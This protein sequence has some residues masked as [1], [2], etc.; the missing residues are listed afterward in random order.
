MIDVIVR[1]T[2]HRCALRRLPLATEEDHGAHSV[3][4]SVQAFQV[5]WIA[6]GGLLAWWRRRQKTAGERLS[7]P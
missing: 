4:S 6:C 1:R 5:C 2:D 3:P 7:D